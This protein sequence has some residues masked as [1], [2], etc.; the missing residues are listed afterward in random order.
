[1]QASSSSSSSSSSS[2]PFLCAFS[3][4]AILQLPLLK[5]VTKSNYGGSFYVLFYNFK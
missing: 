5:P 2:F 4:Q 1:M 3:P